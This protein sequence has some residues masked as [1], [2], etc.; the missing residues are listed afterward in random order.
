MRAAVAGTLYD[1]PQPPGSSVYSSYT[2]QFVNGQLVAN[3]GCNTVEMAVMVDARTVTTSGNPTSTGAACRKSALRDAYDREMFKVSLGWT[4]SAGQLTL[5]TA[6]GDTYAGSNLCREIP[7]RPPR[8]EAR[9]D[10]GK[11]IDW[12]S[13]PHLHRAR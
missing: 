4:V 13:V 10:R 7:F 12:G 8:G 5:T 2:V 6:G 9:H 3:D 11:L 1:S